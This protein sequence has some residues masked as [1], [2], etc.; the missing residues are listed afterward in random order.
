MRIRASYLAAA[1]SLAFAA[2]ANATIVGSTYD[3][4]T[5][6][7]GSTQIVPPGGPTVH[8]DPANPGFC[9]GP[10][11]G[12][13]GGNGLS[14]SFAFAQLTPTQDTITF[15][16]FGSTN[17]F[18]GTFT[19]DLG[20]FVTVDG[21]AITGVSYVSGNLNNGNFTSVTFD[22]TD[23]DFTGSTTNGFSALGGST[24][25]FSVATTGPQAAVP[26]PASLVLLGGGLLGMGVMRR[27]RSR[28]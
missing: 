18:T 4:S 22:G 5:S 17:T 8:T 11:V 15:T 26:E 7:T 12:C 19:I 9:V 6:A 16:F 28:M 27:R 21:E 13:A 14:G 1:L 20:N 3:F 25:V 23:A 2:N 10:P 24:V